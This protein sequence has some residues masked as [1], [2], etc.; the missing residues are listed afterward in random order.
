MTTFP[1]TYAKY[2]SRK[3]ETEFK[4]IPDRDLGTGVYITFKILPCV[5]FT[6]LRAKFPQQLKKILK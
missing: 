4:N 5:T 2:K 6:M 1:K 3:H